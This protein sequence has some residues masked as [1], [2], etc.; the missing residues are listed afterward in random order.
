[1]IFNSLKITGFK[2]FAEPE[3]ITI[4]DGLTGIV[5]PNGCGKSNI[6]EA[7]RWLMGESSAKSMRGDELEDIIFAGSDQRPQR[8]FAEVTLSLDNSARSAPVS[9]NDGDDIEIIRRLDR[10]KGSNFKINGKNVRA[11]DVQL[12][13]ADIATGARSSGI[14]SQ[15]KVA[16]IINAKPTERRSLIEEAAHIRGL[17]QR[18]HEAELRLNSTDTNLERL[19]DVLI[20]LEEQKVT[21]NK[22][23]RQAARYRSVADRIRKANA[24]LLLARFTTSSK[25]LEAVRAI[26]REEEVTMATATKDAALK[27]RAYNDHF[28][29]LPPLR[30]EEADVV[31]KLQRLTLEREA[32]NKEEER[33]KKAAENAKIQQQQIKADTAREQQLMDD[34]ANA[35]ETLT[36]EKEQLDLAHVDDEPKSLIIAENLAKTRAAANQAEQA[37]AE[38]T[39]RKLEASRRTERLNQQIQHYKKQLVQCEAALTHLNLDVIKANIETTE[40]DFKT[41]ETSAAHAKSHRQN[42]ETELEAAEEASDLAQKRYSEVYEEFTRI[43]AEAEALR[44]LINRSNQDG[45]K[46]TAPPALKS[47]TPKEGFEIALAAAFADGLTAPIGSHENDHWLEYKKPVDLTPP[48]NTLPL[49]DTAELPDALLAAATGIGIVADAEEAATRQKDLQ[50]GQALTTREGGVWRWDGFVKPIG[51]ITPAA[52][53]LQQEARLRQ[54]NTMLDAADEAAKTANDHNDKAKA[55]LKKLQE[56]THA[57]RNAAQQ[58]EQAAMRAMHDNNNAKIAYDNALMREKDLREN[59]TQFQQNISASEEEL[60]QA[61]DGVTLFENIETLKTQAEECRQSLAN[62]M[63][64]EREIQIIRKERGERQNQIKQNFVIW[65]ERKEGAHQRL[66]EL[67]KRQSEAELAAERLIS[68]PSNIADERAKLSALIETATTERQDATDRLSVAETTMRQAETARLDAEK[69]L[70]NAREQ[71]IRTESA[72][73]LALQ[74]VNTITAA[75]KEKFGVRPEGLF[76]LADINSDTAFDHDDD[77]LKVLQD[78]Y[79]RLLRERDNMGPVNLRAEVEVKELQSKITEIEQERDDLRQAIEKLRTGIAEL[80]REGRERLLK[81]FTIVNKH[82]ENLFT[83]LFNGGAAELSLTKGDDP[84]EAGLDIYARPPGKKMQALSLLS[85]G[86]QALTAL[87]LIF[88]IFLTNPSP[89]VILDEVDAPLDDG[90][91]ARFCDMLSQIAEQTNTRFLIITHHRL[92]MARMER[93]YGVTMEQKGVSNIVSVDLQTAEKYKESA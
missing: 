21:L 75:I 78:R 92:T 54:L 57:A 25:K 43:R 45:D 83:K 81:N 28:E 68:Q 55:H 26:L 15:G 7:I 34:A 66:N 51:A 77:A 12:L 35:L 9:F 5:G 31:A 82:F 72:R 42:N 11:K 38:A 70:S 63:G 1:M 20:Q 14:V 2:S 61:N 53:M 52:I 65:S 59:L 62:A 89:L 22:Q 32:L 17:R 69:L 41:K 40:K 37:L 79:E 30:K 33:L 13:F 84:L 90:N 86:E 3:Y 48:E 19:V 56:K 10:G 58:E 4:H 67:A 39:A 23:A 49:V 47:V 91:V 87:A 88:S 46:K 50:P 64:A 29:K 36:K 85:G 76:A 27:T 74:N 71:F 8:N 60:N 18:R 73:D 80:N 16:S 6:V 93:L 44:S 24:M